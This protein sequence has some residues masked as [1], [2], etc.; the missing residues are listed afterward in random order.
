[1]ATWLLDRLYA[2]KDQPTL[3]F[4]FQGTAHWMRALAIVMKGGQFDNAALRSHY[5]SVQRRQ[6][7]TKADTLAYDALLM[8]LHNVASVQALTATSAPYDVVRAGIVAWYYAIY[9][10][11]KAMIAAASGSDPQTHAKAAS[12]WKLE[13]VDRG[14]AV[15]PFSYSVSDLTPASVKTQMASLR[16]GNRHDLSVAP[17]N[18]QSAFGGVM[19]YLSGTAV[20]ARWETEEMVK[21]SS[22]FKALGVTN[23]KTKAAQNL[24]DRALAHEKVCF[25]TQA[26]RYRG[27]A[28]YRDSPYLSYGANRTATVT[29][30]ISDM[31]LVAEKFTLMACHFVAKR[32]EKRTW[33]SFVGDVTAN[34]RFTLPIDLNQV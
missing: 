17:T 6:V 26:F 32:T 3:R 28:N 24:R 4:A 9:S 21:T 25:M 7:N 8:A 10:A 23:F 2:A 33:P 20:Y 12:V 18:A 30:M 19:S 13:I 11:A 5:A 16:A 31:A 34:A 1:M 29:T 27:K 22:A 14:L 15:P